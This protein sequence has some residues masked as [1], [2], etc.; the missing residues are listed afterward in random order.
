MNR[1]ANNPIVPRKMD[2]DFDPGELPK[3]WFGGNPFV[4]HYANGMH[5]VFPEGERFFI[6]SVKH[7]LDQIDDDALKD[8]A[9]QF[10]Q[11]EAQHGR[12]H[13]MSFEVLEA[14]G[15][16]VRA[17]LHD[18][19]K[20]QMGRVERYLPPLLKLSITVALEHLTAAMGANALTDD[21][22]ERMHPTML[23]LVRWHASEEI[24]HKSVA[25][26][27]LSRVSSSY[28]LRVSGMVLGLIGLQL[29]SGRAARALLKQDNLTRE[30][31][32]RFI[33]EAQE[34]QKHFSRM[35]RRAIVDYL[36][37]GFHPDQ[38]DNYHLA[39][40][41]LGSIGRLTA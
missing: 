9:R 14:H 33:G 19:E 1:E 25:F 40:D 30:E 37:P 23:A 2:F 4:T 11:Q 39:R 31:H 35:M 34:R 18:F 38:E 16:D 15:Y 10:F 21:Y 28:L 6:R 20:V 13:G 8:R 29:F 26:D 7:Y 36:K 5:I 12:E 17:L 24:E 22:L 3:W 41:Y 32:D 27:V